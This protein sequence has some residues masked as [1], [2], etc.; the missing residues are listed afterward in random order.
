MSRNRYR[1]ENYFDTFGPKRVDA[2]GSK[3]CHPAHLSE[4]SPTQAWIFELSLN[5]PKFDPVCDIFM[6]AFGPKRVDV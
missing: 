5:C 3:F 2:K 6:T 4:N 1:F